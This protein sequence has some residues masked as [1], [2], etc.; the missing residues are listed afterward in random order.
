MKRM[1]VFLMLAVLIALPVANVFAVSEAAV[2]F[3]MISPGARAAGMGEAFVA[4][5]DDATAVYWNPAGLAFQRGRE[6]SIMHA[7][8]LPQLV[9][10]MSY[11]FVA[12]RQ[13]VESLGGTIGGNVT[14]LNLGEQYYTD[15]NGPEIL[16]TF[17]SFDLAVSL[18]YATELTPNLG[19]GVS[20][21]YIQ[22]NLAPMGAG[23]E[24]GT[25]K[26]NSFAV[27]LGLLYKLKF[28]PGLG[29]G[30]NLSKM[31]P[32]MLPRRILFQPI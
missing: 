7:K 10:D 2:L 30:M 3:L 9:S 12:Y 19:M 28:M 27:D 26:G 1:I 18:S 17:R 13:Y 22:S 21:R 32:K 23:E 24:Q 4:Q 25:G 11:E 15:E 5:S 8:W 16:D 20:M 14:F 29:F 31:G 6:I